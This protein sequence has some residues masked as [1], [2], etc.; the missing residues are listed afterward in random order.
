M[1]VWSI[2]IQNL[3]GLTNGIK[4]FH[5]NCYYVRQALGFYAGS[6]T[7]IV[8]CRRRLC[9]HNWNSLLQPE[10]ST[11]CV[12]QIKFTQ[13]MF[14]QIRFMQIR[15]MQIKFMQIKFMQI[16]FMQ[17][18]CMQIKCMQ[19]NYIKINYKQIKC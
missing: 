13:I 17:I 11:V 12:N 19:I 16:K 1:K 3:N 6:M 15:F 18:M 5:D 8:K 7:V 14:V 4:H 2:W 10:I 9:G